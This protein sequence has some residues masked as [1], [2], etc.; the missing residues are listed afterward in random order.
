MGCWARSRDS[1][2]PRPSKLAWSSRARDRAAWTVDDV[3]GLVARSAE[4]EGA[5]G[6]VQASVELLKGVDAGGVE[7]GHI[8]EAEDDDIAEGVQ[9]AGGFGELFCRAEEE[10]SVDAE[11]AD[12]GGNL[13]VLKN[14]RLSVAQVFGGDGGDGGGGGY[15]VDV[16]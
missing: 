16:K 8:A 12:V 5:A 6:L 13:F 3:A 10:R 14:M 4:E 2:G 7:G 9:I 15:A 1:S 11:D